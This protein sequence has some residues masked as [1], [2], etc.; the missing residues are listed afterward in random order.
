MLAVFKREFK[1]YFNSPIAYILIGLFMLLSSYFFLSNLSTQSADFNNNLS[2]MSFLLLFIVPILTMRI[3]AEERK[4]GTEVMLIT[5]PV[6]VS[7]IVMGKYLAS[8][9]V[10]LVMTAVSFIFPIIIIIF[11][12]PA[13]AKLIGGYVGFILLGCAFIAIG[14]FASSLTESQVVAAVISFV[15]LLTMWIMDF[16]SSFTSGLLAKVLDWFSLYARY[17]DFSDGILSLSPIIYYLSFCFI[18]VFL[19][20][21]IIEKRRWSQG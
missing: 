12:Q 8:V 4:N 2:S 16:L 14:V 5:S 19:T 13:M 6:S 18:F 1:A 21:R 20:I 10:F 11:G 9:S 7:K 17:V 15:I 3:I